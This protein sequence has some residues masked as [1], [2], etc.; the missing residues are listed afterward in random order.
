[1]TTTIHVHTHTNPEGIYGFDARGIAKRFRHA[2]IFGALDALQPGEVMR[3]VNDHDPIP[4][5]QQMQARYGNAVEIAY[6]AREPEGVMIDF[7]KRA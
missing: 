2:A 1:M 3:F 5:L 4:L 7:I 6:R